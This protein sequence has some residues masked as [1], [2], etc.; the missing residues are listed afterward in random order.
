MQ[1][2]VLRALEFDRIR[3]ALASRALTPLGRERALAVEP[4]EDPEVVRD[5]L[6]LTSDAVGFVGEGGSLALSAPED[7]LTTIEILHV[8][9]HPL[10]PMA[11]RGLARLFDSLGMVTTSLLRSG[12]PRLAAIAGRAASFVDEVAAIERA[13]EP[14]GDISDRASA[15]LRDIRDSLR[16]QR[17]KLRSSLDTLARGRDTTKYVQDQIVTDRNGRYVLVVRSEHRESIPGIVHGSSS[18]GASVYLEPLATV[19]LNND[20]VEL[21]EREKAEIHRILTALTA[22]FRAR[23]GD[24]H[25]TLNVAE[26]I[27]ELHARADLARRVD[28]RA[29][30]LS[31]DGRL[32]FKGARHP[33]LIPAIR[34]LTEETGSSRPGLL[35]ARVVIA[36]DLVITPPASVLV[37]SGP[38]TGGKTVALKAFGLLALMAQAGL[39]IPVDDDS[40]FTPFRSVFADIGDEQSIA[41]SLSTFSAHMAHIVA[42]DRALELPALVLL[43]EVGSGTDPAEGGALGA[44]IVDHFRRRGAMVI[45]TTHDE[46]MKSYAA[47]T[48]GVV[49]AGFGFNPDTYAPTYRLLYGAPGRSLALEIAARLGLPD[50]VIA[51]ARTR[52]SERESLLAAHLARMDQELAVLARE[53]DALATERETLSTERQH[54]LDREARLVEREA[55]LKRR[56]D[57]KVSEKLREAR[58]EIDRI[59][60]TLKLKADAMAQR[61]SERA[62]TRGPVLSTGEVG[63]LRAEAKA[64]VAAVGAALGQEASVVPPAMLTAPPAVGDN[65]FVATFSALAIVRAVSGRHV[66]V[67]VRGKRMRVALGDLRRPDAHN[68]AKDTPTTDHRVRID[69]AARPGEV[70]RDLVLVGSTVD[71]AIA[72][73]EKFLDDALLGDERRLRFVH[74]HGTGRLREGLTKFLRE[75]PLVAAVTP[76]SDREGGAGATIVELK[77]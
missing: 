21:V 23:P 22:A 76:A 74:G 62:A 29:P 34:E 53:R 71:E 6:A 11:L 3:E 67:E 40:V 57:D 2:A 48:A 54:V 26:E 9:D 56:F 28:G 64:G 30:A 19:S 77:E 10:E 65:V 16:R 31:R 47:T 15:A 5:A 18:S 1:A 42:M 69:A 13:I 32:E 73:A 7:L 44:A 37:I 8:A 58:V 46:A 41:N 24:L 38:N 27:D 49:T 70:T 50:D 12:G 55:V 35:D 60:G 45:A 17:A 43:D 72:K 75:H 59:V 4:A 61:A 36:S 25:E 39:L 68:A 51:D 52:R 14:N 20:V 63:G 33:L 66:D